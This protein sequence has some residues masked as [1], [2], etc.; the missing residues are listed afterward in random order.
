MFPPRISWAASRFSIFYAM[1]HLQPFSVNAGLRRLSRSRLGPGEATDGRARRT[2]TGCRR[3]LRPGNE[4]AL[5]S[6]LLQ[7]ASY[8]RDLGPWFEYLG[9]FL[10]ALGHHVPLRVP[11]DRVSHELLPW[12][13]KPPLG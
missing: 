4:S 3:G 13:S 10:R 11:G 5:D 9:R 6:L 8:L 7:F 12:N 1:I 2:A